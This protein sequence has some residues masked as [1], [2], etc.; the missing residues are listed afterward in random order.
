MHRLPAGY[1]SACLPHHPHACRTAACWLRRQ[2]SV[3]AIVIIFAIIVIMVKHT[4]NEL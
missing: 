1:G 4:Q 3:I 2:Y